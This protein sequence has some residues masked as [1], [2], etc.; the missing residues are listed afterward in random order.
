[1]NLYFIVEGKTE[2]KVYPDWLSYLLP[3][4]RR[5]NRSNKVESKNYFLIT[6]GGYPAIYELLATAIEEI[7]LIGK[8]DYLVLC[9]DAEESSVDGLRQEVQEK[10]QELSIANNFSL[11]NTQIKVIVQNRCI[12]TWFL[13][14]RKIYSRQPQEPKLLNYT[15]YYNVSTDCPELMGQYNYDVHAHF[16]VDYL[17]ELLVAKN[18]QY[19]KTMP[20]DVQEEYYL[21]ELQTR[22]SRQSTHLPTFQYFLEFCESV[23]AKLLN[24]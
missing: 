14:N 12:E 6:A 10:I 19:S 23:R 24:L 20:R 1:M 22:V 2:L 16:H 17:K 4:L 3:E 21:Q 18:I 13:G 9:L 5:V 15:R 7:I 11:G 8:Y